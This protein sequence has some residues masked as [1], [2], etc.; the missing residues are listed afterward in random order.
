MHSLK[1]EN[2]PFQA[3]DLRTWKIPFASSPLKLLFMDSAASLGDS[4]ITFLPLFTLTI[5]Y[6]KPMVR[7]LNYTPTPPFLSSCS[8]MEWRLLFS[9]MPETGI[10]ATKFSLQDCSCSFLRP[11]FLFLSACYSDNTLQ[12]HCITP[13]ILSTSVGSHGL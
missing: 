6:L 2:Q 8:P 10:T 5:F 3:V 11:R 4:L 9:D 1:K 12:I 13:K 7:L